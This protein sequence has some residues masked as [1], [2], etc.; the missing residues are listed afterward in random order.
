MQLLVNYGKTKQATVWA[1]E[2]VKLSSLHT[3]VLLSPLT[4]SSASPPQ[5]LRPLSLFLSHISRPS[6]EVQLCTGCLCLAEK[7]QHVLCLALGTRVTLARTQCWSP[8]ALL[9][10]SPLCLATDFHHTCGSFSFEISTFCQTYMKT[11][12]KSG[13]KRHWQAG[14]EWDTINLSSVGSQGR[15]EH[16]G[17]QTLHICNCLGMRWPPGRC[18]PS[19]Q[20]QAASRG[21]GENQPAVVIS[22]LP[23]LFLTIEAPSDCS[24][25]PPSGRGIGFFSK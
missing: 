18:P 14:R 24:T 6:P 9:L 10:P 1:A 19:F 17:G 7:G 3:C 5:A 16:P 13:D 4:V 2:L 20:G 23:Y 25:F 11:N 15:Q 22:K 21:S 12:P 8:W